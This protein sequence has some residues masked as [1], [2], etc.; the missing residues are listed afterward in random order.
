MMGKVALLKENNV[1]S[2]SNKVLVQPENKKIASIWVLFLVSDPKLM[3]TISGVYQSMKNSFIQKLTVNEKLDNYWV[4]QIMHPYFKDTLTKATDEI[5][6]KN[7]GIELNICVDSTPYGLAS[8][9]NQSKNNKEI[10][11]STLF[12]DRRQDFNIS[13][14]EIKQE[15]KQH[16]INP[17]IKKQCDKLSCLDYVSKQATNVSPVEND[18]SK[19]LYEGEQWVLQINLLDKLYKFVDTCFLSKS[20]SYQDILLKLDSVFSEL[21]SNEVSVSDSMK[22]LVT[23]LYDLKL[24]YPSQWSNISKLVRQH[25]L[26]N[27]CLMDPL[28]KRAYE[29]PRGYAGDAGLMDYFYFG[30]KKNEAITTIGQSILKCMRETPAGSA[31][32]SRARVIGETIDTLRRNSDRKIRVL[33]I[34]CGH[35]RE[36][37]TSEAFMNNQVELV[38]M[39]QD[40][41][42]LAL[43]SK[44]YAAQDVITIQNSVKNILQRKGL[45]DLGHFDLI[46]ASGLFDYLKDRVATK[47]TEIMFEMVAPGGRVFITNYLPNTVYSGYME[48]VMDW[49]LIYRSLHD[50]EKLARYI[51]LNKVEDKRVFM[52]KNRRVAFLEINKVKT[53]SASFYFNDISS[54][55]LK[56]W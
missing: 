56:Q 31:V 11:V 3:N 49:P 50:L 45:N 32:R 54:D 33:S 48:S 44:E 21:K 20:E 51:P 39:D 47:L 22:T 41:E 7:I 4:F 1:S 52:E 9:I 13:F 46:F 42:S 55:C 53:E 26:F 43:I 17:E 40:E 15:I 19:R 36:L 24:T 12:V 2:L 29:K 14:E 6:N 8:K 38:A 25:P 27:L 16:T 35:C 23:A 34:A 5:K 37:S 18:L 10:V 28:T 30:C